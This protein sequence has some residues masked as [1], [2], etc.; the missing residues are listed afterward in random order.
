MGQ[1]TY[2][3]GL[4]AHP[5]AKRGK[6]GG[7]GRQVSGLFH[8]RALWWRGGSSL[9]QLQEGLDPSEHF[10]PGPLSSC[11]GASLCPRGS[12]HPA[13]SILP[14]MAQ[15]P[16]PSWARRLGLFPLEREE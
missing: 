11:E 1:P 5:V 16:K 2:M 7:Q 13:G 6:G 9:H 4:P 15:N 8:P 10:A 3:P 12:P 14:L